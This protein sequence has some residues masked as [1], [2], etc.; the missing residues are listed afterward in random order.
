[1]ERQFSIGLVAGFL[2]SGVACIMITVSLQLGIGLFALGC[3][4][5]FL[6][7]YPKSPVRRQWWSISNKLSITPG[8][9]S[10]IRVNANDENFTIG[11]GT[12]A[13]SSFYVE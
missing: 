11:V 12:V 8:D 1:M 10:V 9:N 4:L 3:I 13:M 6:F 7:V 2:I 5:G